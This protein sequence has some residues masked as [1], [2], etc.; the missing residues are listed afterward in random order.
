MRQSSIKIGKTQFRA[1]WFSGLH[2]GTKV[3]VSVPLRDNKTRAFVEYQG[4]KEWVYSVKKFAQGDPAGLKKSKLFQAEGLA[5]IEE[6]RKNFD[7]AVSTFENL[8]ATILKTEPDA[9]DPEIWSIGADKTARELLAS[10]QVVEM[11]PGAAMTMIADTPG[12]GKTS[13]V[14][15]YTA[16]KPN[17]VHFTAVKGGHK[18]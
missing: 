3:K 16:N 8:K 10:L 17:F 18:G 2:A 1:T 11:I 9:P 13:A 4:R 6:L 5:A 14:L 12:I 7:P 15:D